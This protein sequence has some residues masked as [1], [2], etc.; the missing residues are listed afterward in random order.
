[1]PRLYCTLC[2]HKWI[3][4]IYDVWSCP[5]CEIGAADYEVIEHD[6]AEIKEFFT[7]FEKA[8]NNINKFEVLKKGSVFPAFL[9][10]AELSESLLDLLVIFFDH[11]L[12]YIDTFNIRKD[13]QR[14]ID[15]LNAYIENGFIS[16]FNWNKKLYT[17]ITLKRP[18]IIMDEIGRTKWFFFHTYIQ[19]F[20]KIQTSIDLGFASQETLRA[21]LKDVPFWREMSNEKDRT[22]MLLYLGAHDHIFNRL[23]EF[24]ILCNILD[25]NILT[26]TYL[27]NFIKLKYRIEFN[28]L[29]KIQNILLNLIEWYSNKIS[30][31]PK[32][33]KPDTLIKYRNEI[34]RNEFI[35]YVINQYNKVKVRTCI[36]NSKIVQE[37]SDSIDKKLE[38]ARKISGKSYK[39]KQII[40]SGL[41]GTLGSL[42]GGSVGAFVG[43]IGSSLTA[44]G[45]EHFDRKSVE[46]WSSFFIE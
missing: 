3:V 14:I 1:M 26:D 10:E 44:L 36:P 4:N 5:N 22:N 46:H 41:I 21:S 34:D 23:N 43:G 15:K 28:E 9:H 39:T 40:L 12:L 45:V 17:P 30:E 24:T 33:E 32:F 25:C 6:P 35:S 7:I 38:L 8:K 29:S 18:H 13:K 42:I 20:S 37:I 31:Y 11:T 19:R 2:G 16:I 27:S